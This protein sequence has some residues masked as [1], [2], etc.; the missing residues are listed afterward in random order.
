[1]LQEFKEEDFVWLFL[2]VLKEK[3]NTY[4][5]AKTYHHFFSVFFLKTNT[6]Q[7]IAVK[8]VNRKFKQE[9]S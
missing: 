9:K 1:M 5:R 6:K 4:E 3:K 8:F 7:E 2:K